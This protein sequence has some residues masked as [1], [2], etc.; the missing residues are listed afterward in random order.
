MVELL[1]IIR[2]MVPGILFNFRKP[3]ART[4]GEVGPRA[5]ACERG[6]VATYTCVVRMNMHACVYL[7]VV[8]WVGRL[9]CFCTHNYGQFVFRAVL[10]FMAT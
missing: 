7:H 6:G 10:Y 2:T 8:G 3:I 1:L 9:V 5:A 4:W